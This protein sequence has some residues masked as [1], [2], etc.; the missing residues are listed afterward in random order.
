MQIHDRNCLENSKKVKKKRT[1]YVFSPFIGRIKISRLS[2][3]GEYCF[4]LNMFNWNFM[5]EGLW[6][7]EFQRVLSKVIGDN[8]DKLFNYG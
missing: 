4:N 2:H 8:S 1:L 3:V 7:T 6:F 5:R